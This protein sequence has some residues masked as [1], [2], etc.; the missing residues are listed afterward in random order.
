[1]GTHEISDPNIEY[2][3]NRKAYLP[4]DLAKIEDHEALWKAREG[5]YKDAYNTPLT[6]D[7]QALYDIWYPMAVDSALINPMDHG[8]YDIPGFW[9]SGQWKS[10]DGRGHGTDT[11]K[12]PNHITFSDES[13]WSSQQ[14][15][16]PFE[17]GSWDETGGFMPGKHNFFYNEE[18]D[19][20]FNRERAHWESKGIEN[21]V[22]EH[23]YG[24]TPL[25]DRKEKVRQDNT[26][27]NLD[28]IPEESFNIE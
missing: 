13:K 27:V 23:L 25:L 3:R 10:K 11:F 8:V 7:E 1:M 5:Y 22:P 6:D 28:L 9:Q 15:G 4:K 20:E 18:I 21:A 26:S 14:G 12:K 19:R 16:S 24:T 2:I 17:G